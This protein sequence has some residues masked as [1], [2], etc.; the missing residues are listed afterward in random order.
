M[1]F[2]GGGTTAP[3]MR[4]DEFPPVP[5]SN[6][7]R[8][9]TTAAGSKCHARCTWVPG[10][11]RFAI[12]SLLR[13][14]QPAGDAG[15]RS[16]VCERAFTAAVGPP[17]SWASRRLTASVPFFPCSA[18]RPPEAAEADPPCSVGERRT[19]ARVSRKP[20]SPWSGI[21]ASVS[22]CG[23]IIGAPC[24]AVGASRPRE[25]EAPRCSDRRTAARSKTHEGVGRRQQLQLP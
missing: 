23:R 7:S 21:R 24:E 19:G 11:R 8:T 2:P 12:S 9:G 17:R 20:G 15:W 13:G 18:A 16:V 3:S 1:V 10:T 6:S 14:T 4:I 22:V 25:C 5:R